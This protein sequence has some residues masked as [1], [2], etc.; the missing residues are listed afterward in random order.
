MSDPQTLGVREKKRRETYLG[1]GGKDGNQ[2]G[3]ASYPTETCPANRE[4]KF[5]RGN[6]L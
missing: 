1:R 6:S 5:V 2:I 3:W 4:K